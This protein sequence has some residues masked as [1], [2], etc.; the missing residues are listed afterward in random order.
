MAHEKAYN[1]MRAPRDRLATL[2]RMDAA[3]RASDASA[4]RIDQAEVDLE[5]RRAQLEATT[6][7]LK[8]RA[9]VFLDRWTPAVR[10]ALLA[11]RVLHGDALVEQSRCFDVFASDASEREGSV[12]HAKE[13]ARAF[14]DDDRSS[15]P[16]LTPDGSVAT[17][18]C[19]RD[20]QRETSAPE[21]TTA[22]A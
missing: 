1:H 10:E 20:E 12:E 21:V 14:L 6:R 19:V 8:Q 13:R 15:S 3:R 16:P 7:M 5:K 17:A 11:S 9:R 2:M 22:A 4:K 18:M